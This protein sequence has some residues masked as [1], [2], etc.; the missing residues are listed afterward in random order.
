M[1]KFQKKIVTAISFIAILG[2]PLLINAE[3]GN[4]MSGVGGSCIASGNCTFSDLMIVVINVS[5]WILG[6][7]GAVALGFLI[8]GGAMLI[9]SGGNEQMVEKGRKMITGSIIG[10]IIILTAW[11]FV[12][13]IIIALTGKTDATIFE[14]FNWFQLI[15]R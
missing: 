12:N 5:E 11:V 2:A 10:L 1:K 4:L 8:F 7:A 13:L 14:G 9:I 6:I 15:N 3:T